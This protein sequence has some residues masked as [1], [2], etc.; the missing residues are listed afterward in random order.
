LASALIAVGFTHLALRF[1]PVVLKAQPVPSIQVA[2]TNPPAPGPTPKG[3]VLD[4]AQ[5][6]SIVVVGTSVTVG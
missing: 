5:D 2:W 4:A 1:D 6:R 3:P